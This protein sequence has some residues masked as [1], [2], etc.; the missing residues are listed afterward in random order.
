MATWKKKLA[1]YFVIISLIMYFIHYTIFKDFYFISKYVMAQLG[2]LPISTLIVGI[3]I[4]QFMANRQ[5]KEMLEKLNKLI[6]VFFNEV[7]Q[8][9]VFVM[10]EFQV[11]HQ[12]FYENFKDIEHWEDRDF[13]NMKRKLLDYE[14]TI[15]IN[16]GDLQKLK[17][18][19]Q[20]ERQFMIDL[21]ENQNLLEHDKF[22]DL[23]WAILHINNEFMVQD[24]L[25]TLTKEDME[26]ITGDIL[27]AYKLLVLEWM[28]HMK[29]IKDNYPYLFSLAL[30]TMALREQRKIKKSKE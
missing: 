5:K 19:L 15:D 7:G 23:I 28:D 29:H 10:K 24:R 18:L 30:R 9:L 21:L 17:E 2:F 3:V 20:Q 14:Y 4:N 16:L 12:S 8:K 1:F 22:T 11:D 13:H 6:S 27:R 25:D 26:H